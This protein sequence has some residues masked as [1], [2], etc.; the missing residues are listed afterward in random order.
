[1]NFA[2]Y[3]EEYRYPA[4]INWKFMLNNSS[5]LTNYNRRPAMTMN[6]SSFE[7]VWSRVLRKSGQKW[8]FNLLPSII[9]K[10][11]HYTSSGGI[12]AKSMSGLMAAGLGLVIFT[13]SYS[14]V[15]DRDM[16][17][18]I[19]QSLTASEDHF[20]VDFAAAA[21]LATASLSS[22]LP[23]ILP[24]ILPGILPDIMITGL[25]PVGQSMIGTE[26]LGADSFEQAVTAQRPVVAQLTINREL[27]GD[28]VVTIAHIGKGNYFS[29]GSIP[30][31]QSLMGPLDADKKQSLAFVKPKPSIEAFKIAAA[32][33]FF[34]E[35]E[36]S[37]LAKLPTLVASLVRESKNSILAYAPEDT[38]KY[39]PFAAVLRDEG[40]ISIVPKL[41][42]Y[43]HSWADD[44]LPKASFSKAQQKCLA[45]GIYFEA[46]GEPVRGQA[47][48]AQV[49]LNRVRNPAYPNSIC[50]VVYQN[51]TR[52]NACQ[53][54]FACDRVR[55]RIRSQRLWKLALQV[56]KETTAGRIWLSQ[57][58]SSTHYHATYVR[59][60]WAKH[61]K[62]VG[63]IG[64]HVFYRTKGGG[65]S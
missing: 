4:F 50:G 11:S 24:N 47:A 28:R 32:F 43:D 10:A 54:S 33:Q 19:K 53:F 58:G 31:H 60:K 7:F 12:K 1:V 65:W 3:Q 64:L 22:S 57:V 8:Q 49:I 2:N 61:M 40:P 41:N 36:K 46:R 44:P 23:D 45:S 16:L 38:V 55:D 14:T 35:A 27:K 18:P 29:A 20:S 26:D 59:P 15:S 17:D 9:Q 37:A 34:G 30:R 5:R 42:D 63:K 51:R 6:V 48:V 62:K 56:A 52:L 21:D 39:S 25:T 13:G